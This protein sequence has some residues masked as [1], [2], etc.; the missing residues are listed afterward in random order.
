MVEIQ[1]KMMK[2]ILVTTD[3]RRKNL[4]FVSEE[5]KSLSLEEAINL[6]GA[7]KMEG[8][9]A[10]DRS[11]GTYLR[12]KPSI[13]KSEEFETLSITGRNLLSYAQ[14]ARRGVSTPALNRY[15]ELYLASLKEGNLFIKPVGQPKVLTAAVKEKFLPHR[16]HILMAAKKFNI[17][18]I[19]LGAIII[20]EIARL[21]PFESIFDALG[22]RIVGWNVSVGIAQV[23]V[24]TAHDLIKKGAYHPNPDDTK[25]PFN[26]LTNAGRA[27]LYTYLIQPKY[28]IFFAAGFIRFVIDFWKADIDLA[29]RPEIIATLY[30][31]GYGKPHPEPEPDER[32]KQIAKEFYRLSKRW[33][34]KK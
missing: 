26:R 31:Q 21:K 6:A 22:A 23:K 29:K 33:L 24:D 32:G 19:L 27:Y 18:P 28:N 20:D 3:T 16:L 1:P 5:L 7:G 17:D 8:V 9:Y 4:V 2:I 11:T 25:L 14:D 10:V 15:V 13:P 34:Q 12:T 30:H